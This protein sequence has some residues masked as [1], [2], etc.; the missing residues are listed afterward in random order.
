MPTQCTPS[1]EWGTHWDFSDG[2]G[3]LHFKGC[4]GSTLSMNSGTDNTIGYLMG[5]NPSGTKYVVQCEADYTSLLNYAA[6]V[7]TLGEGNTRLDDW[8]AFYVDLFD[9]LGL[10]WLLGISTVTGGYGIDQYAAPG[11]IGRVTY[12][13]PGYD[14]EWYTPADATYCSSYESLLGPG[15]DFIESECSENFIGYQMES[16]YTNYLQWLHDRTDYWITVKDWTGWT[17]TKDNSNVSYMTGTDEDGNDL[18]PVPTVQDRFALVDEISIEIFYPSYVPLMLNWQQQAIDYDPNMPI[19]FNVDMICRSID[20]NA[21]DVYNPY[22]NW[23]VTQGVGQ[24][25]NRCWWERLGAM[26]LYNYF[27][28]RFGAY[29]AMTYNLVESAWPYGGQDWE[30]P[31]A[32]HMDLMER[33]YI[34]SDIKRDQSLTVE[35]DFE[36]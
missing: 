12:R 6:D 20:N 13:T 32:W 7:A 34:I 15:F 28:E 24:P 26:Q 5:D 10:K 1:W 2:S 35:W 27:H 4:D 21:V 36:P 11:Y 17:N 31:P 30:T 19:D 29:D 14:A 18:D 33:M 9:S 25:A 23:W 16:E 22:N 8:K 3:T